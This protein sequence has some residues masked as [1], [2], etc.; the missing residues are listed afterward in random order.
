M[1]IE[2]A[3]EKRRSYYQLNKELPVSEDEVKALITRVTELVPDA[4][5]MHSARVVVALGKKQDEL[6]DAI[7]DAF[8]GKVAREKINGFKAAAGTIL[9]FYDEDVVKAMQE[10]FAPYAQNFPIWASQANGMLQINLWTALREQGIGAN[11]QHY[12]PVIDETVK[13]MFNIP[14]SW[15]LIAQMP[16]GGIAAEPDSKK[17]EDI[18]KRVV[19]AE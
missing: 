11:I 16:F 10:Q 12:N 13:K 15:K 4:F 17:K 5:N 7:Y 19:F 2:Q 14:D 3:L 6:W 1:A 8:E 18:T 9:Y